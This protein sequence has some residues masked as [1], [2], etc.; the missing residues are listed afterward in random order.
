[1][2]AAIASAVPDQGKLLVVENGAYGRRMHEIATTY[3]ILNTLYRLEY[4]DYPNLAEIES[5]LKQDPTITHLAV[6]HHETT[7]GM[8]NPVEEIC[9]IAHSFNVEVIV[10]A[11]SSYAGIPIDLRKWGAGYLVSSSNKCI[12]GMP[13]LSFVIFRKDLLPKSPYKRRS[14]YFDLYQQYHGFNNSR[15]M[16]FT[17][18]VQVVYALKQAIDEYFRETEIGRWTRYQSNW[19][20][21][22]NGLA[23]LNFKFLVP[24]AQQSKILLAVIDPEDPRYS[25][26]DMHDYLY[27]YGF[28]I[29]PGKGAKNDTFRLAII[30]DLYKSDIEDFLETLKNYIGLRGLKIS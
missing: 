23:Q 25:F 3:N 29:Y 24:L 15:Q 6:V 21:L 9:K 28:T 26:E 22:Y 30:G 18:P 14:F 4:G 5:H 27:R 12:Q 10:D 17:P 20:V 11:I 8:L 2:E 16:P 13:G 19:E 7:T 1:L